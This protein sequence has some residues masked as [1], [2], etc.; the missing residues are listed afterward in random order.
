MF[1]G[2]NL[3]MGNMWW[4]AYNR[5]GA[6]Q[7]IFRDHWRKTLDPAWRLP[8]EKRRCLVSPALMTGSSGCRRE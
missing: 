8:I 3:Q 5:S 2:G 4:D 6:L 7:P 1:G